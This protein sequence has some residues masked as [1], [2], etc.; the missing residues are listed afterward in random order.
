M[1]ACSVTPDLMRNSGSSFPL[2]RWFRRIVF[3]GGLL[4][5]LALLAGLLYEN[6]CE[7]RDHRFNPMPGKLVNVGGMKMHLYC[8]GEGTPAVILDSGLGDSYISWRKVQPEIAKFARV[9]S[10]DRAGVGYSDSSS[11]PRTSS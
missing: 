10:Y 8:T 11:R 1:P 9:C 7:A 2:K 5:F 3:G 6:I 4:A